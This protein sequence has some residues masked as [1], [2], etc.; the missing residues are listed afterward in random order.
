[1]KTRI[2]IMPIAALLFSSIAALCATRRR[3]QSATSELLFG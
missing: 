1:M 3:V 2:F